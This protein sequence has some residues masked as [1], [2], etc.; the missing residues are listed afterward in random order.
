MGTVISGLGVILRPVSAN[1]AAW[2]YAIGRNADA[3]F[4]AGFGDP[5]LDAAGDQR[6]FYLKV[7]DRMDGGAV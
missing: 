2:K 1:Q 7:H 4:A 6:I 5:I 3:K